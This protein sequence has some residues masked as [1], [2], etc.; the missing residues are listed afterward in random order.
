MRFIGLLTLSI[1]F[2]FSEARG[3][4]LVP[5]PSF[6]V[7][8]SCPNAIS[9]IYKATYWI[10]PTANDP[11]YYN[12]CYSGSP[13]GSVDVPH[14]FQG[15]QN[16]RSGNAYAGIACYYGFDSRDYIEVPLTETLVAGRK[17][18]VTFYV[19]LS[20]SSWDGISPIGT[21]F[22]NTLINDQSTISNLPYIAQ[23]NSPQQIPISD[24]TNWI[25]ISGIFTASGGEKYMTI[26]T[27]CPDSLL[28]RDSTIRPRPNPNAKWAYYY[29]DDVSV[30]EIADCI[31]GTDAEICYKDSVQLGTIPD[32]NVAY[33]WQP[34]T[35][36]SDPT[37]A[38]PKASPSTST[39]YTLTQTQCNAVSTATVSVIVKPDCN[40][41][42]NI[43]IPTI[44]IGNQQLFIQGLE[45]NSSLEIFDARG[46]IVFRDLD[47]QNN[48]WS[49]ELSQGIYF[50]RLTRP[51]QQVIEQKLC[52]VR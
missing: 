5:N 21:Y 39:T 16:A 9:Q 11:D 31:P 35:G 32:S 25:M 30:I 40:S 23:V 27:F 45:S 4:N 20:D 42:P 13:N 24:T 44:L 7:F 52:I 49:A 12:A 43:F 18:C 33:S 36:L 3:Q 14:N 48:F 6:E 29:V 37:I 51:D 17:Y 8:S 22:S 26:G 15:F 19:S 50:I 46:R 10:Q 41:A 2:A 1:G 28:A 47:Y 34:T 38:N